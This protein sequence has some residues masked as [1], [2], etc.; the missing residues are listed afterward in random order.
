MTTDSRTSRVLTFRN[1]GGGELS[2]RL[3]LPADGK[4]VANALFAHCFTCSK[5]LSAVVNVS[6][7][8]TRE[9]ISVFRFD[10]TG[11]G[12]SQGE[13]SDT[14]LSSNVEDLV[15]AARFMAQEHIPPEILI[16]H[17][18]GGA[19]VIRAARRV[20][21]SRAV[22]T[23]GAPFDPWHATELFAESHHEIRAKGEARVQ[24]GG[25]PFRVRRELLED[26]RQT[27]LGDA[28]HQLGRALLV[29]HSPLDEV[30]GIDN[31]AQIYTA[32]QH[33]KSFI[34]LDDADHLLTNPADSAY[35]ARV[36]AA[37]AARYVSRSEPRELDEIVA[38]E[39]VVTRTGKTKYRTEIRAGR[40]GAVADEP[41]A[42]GGEDAGP[43]PYDY[44]LAGLGACTGITLRMYADR[45]GWPLEEVT[46]RLRHEKV[47]ALD[48]PKA[49]E[50]ED[51]RM[52]KVQRK[53]V[54]AGDLDREQRERLLEIADKCPVHRTL[55]AG[56]DIETEGADP[57]GVD[58]VERKG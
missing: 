14:D 30:V 42:V 26:L 53:V 34:S 51:A 50:G 41:E 22:V 3:D 16:G 1:P 31:A 27:K 29:L 10:F 44:L 4:P 40:H 25:R 21:S 55:S 18:L 6:R 20:R 56:V 24:I 32:A 23:I 36:I 57:E 54:L 5:D 9:G 58:A 46:V 48:E 7:A 28:L 15:A 19:A 49:E 17:S 8:L 11:H 2:G 52:D 33:P 37:W 45:K 47:H 39:D 35:A 38:S 43:T 12:E 13:F